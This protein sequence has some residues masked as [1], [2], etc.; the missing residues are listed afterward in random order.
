MRCAVHGCNQPPV[1]KGYCAKHYARVRRTGDPDKV[2]KAG[3]LTGLRHEYWR[4]NTDHSE[5]SITRLV[6][7]GRLL[8]AID[9]DA[10]DAKDKI[11]GQNYR[12]GHAQE[13][14]SKR[15]PN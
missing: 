9:K 6:K 1:A 2:G 15:Q 8:Y 13:W 11:I 12:A 4:A 14:I 5:R 3:R 7:A 10:K